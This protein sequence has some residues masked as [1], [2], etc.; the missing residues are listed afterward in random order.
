MPSTNVA[1]LRTRLDTFARS[2]LTLADF[3]PALDVDAELSLND[4]TP[5]LFRALELLEPYG[6]GNP[7][8][9]F[10]ARGVQLAAPPRILKEKHVKLKLRA[11]QTDIAPADSVNGKSTNGLRVTFDALAWN[12]AERIAQTPLLAGDTLDVAFTIGHND[13]PEYGGLELTLRDFKSAAFTK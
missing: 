1:E 13:H 2:R 12:M 6:V 11:G 9:V 4:V 8:P 5:E 7:E 3:D 10:S